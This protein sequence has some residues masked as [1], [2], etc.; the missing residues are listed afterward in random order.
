MQAEALTAGGVLKI[1]ARNNP[2]NGRGDLAWI[3]SLAGMLDEMLQG[4]ALVQAIDNVDQLS[5][6]PE[7]TDLYSTDRREIVTKHEK[8]LWATSDDGVLFPHTEEEV[9]S[10]F[11]GLFTVYVPH[12]E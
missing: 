11:G 6:L 9:I 4:Y 5:G 2:Q 7:G 3:N 8:N 12:D 10:R 1:L